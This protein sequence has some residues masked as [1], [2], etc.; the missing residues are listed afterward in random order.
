MSTR[1]GITICALLVVIAVSSGL[2]MA[3]SATPE[4]VLKQIFTAEAVSGDWFPPRSWRR[5]LWSS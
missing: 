4:Q 3:E 1:R 2:V 5:Y